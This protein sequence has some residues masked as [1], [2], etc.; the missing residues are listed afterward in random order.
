MAQSVLPIKAKETL[1]YGSCDAG[2]S[3]F[4]TRP[5]V[6]SK[7]SAAAKVILSF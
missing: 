3:I 4:V 5:E 6:S 1:V 7:M 2:S